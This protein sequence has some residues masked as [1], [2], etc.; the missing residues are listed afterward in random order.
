MPAIV[1]ALLDFDF[2]EEVELALIDVGTVAD[3]LSGIC[4]IINQ[5]QN[6]GSAYWFVPDLT[7]VDSWAGSEEELK[8]YTEKIEKP[9]SFTQVKAQ[10][11]DGTLDTEEKVVEAV[12][13][14]FKNA[15]DFNEEGSEWYVNACNVEKLFQ[16]LIVKE[17]NVPTSNLCL[18]FP[19]ITV[20][21]MLL[22][23]QSQVNEKLITSSLLQYS[24][25]K[26]NS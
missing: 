20:S 2:V 3:K 15:K 17:N 14:I 5:V 24:G 6:E 1:Y 21:K 23:M 16:A 12:L 25:R 4:A 13:L 11:E 9:M 10:I 18:L 8:A 22:Q 7:S 26:K 19:V